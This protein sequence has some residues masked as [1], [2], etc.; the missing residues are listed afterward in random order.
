[1]KPVDDIEGSVRLAEEDT[2]FLK[3]LEMMA[4]EIESEANK[5]DQLK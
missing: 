4:E 5:S 3:S 1:M 2:D